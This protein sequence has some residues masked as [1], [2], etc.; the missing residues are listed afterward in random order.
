MTKKLFQTAHWLCPLGRGQRGNILMV[1]V[2]GVAVAG[3]FM[4]VVSN[5]TMQTMASSHAQLL[6]GELD[7]VRRL[8][9]ARTNCRATRDFYTRDGS[10]GKLFNRRGDPILPIE[11]GYNRMMLVNWRLMVTSYDEQTGEFVIMAT[12]VDTDQTLPDLF[13][14][15]EAPFVC[16][17]PE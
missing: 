8:L 15:E 14:T 17:P 10:F 4:K 13:A 12:N 6:S 1:V 3:V 7:D 2:T 5:Y 9:V 11:Q 16:P